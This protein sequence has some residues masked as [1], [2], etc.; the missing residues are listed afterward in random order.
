M[1]PSRL[2]QKGGYSMLISALMEA[3]KLATYLICRQ[4][5]TFFTG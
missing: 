2:Y 1:S 3:A 4:F 5:S